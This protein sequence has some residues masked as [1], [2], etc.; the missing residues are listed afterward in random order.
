MIPKNWLRKHTSAGGAPPVDAGAKVGIIIVIGWVFHW[1]AAVKDAQK[2]TGT[3]MRVVY[4]M[5][6]DKI[7]IKIY[8]F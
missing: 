2:E 6:G 3:G 7:G 8:I 4:P 1:A 5:S